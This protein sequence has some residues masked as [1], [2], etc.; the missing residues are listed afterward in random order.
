MSIG[1]KFP[2]QSKR[3]AVEGVA[4]VVPVVMAV[5]ALSCFGMLGLRL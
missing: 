5:A 1:M 2:L 4:V 3:K